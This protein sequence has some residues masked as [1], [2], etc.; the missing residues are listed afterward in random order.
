MLAPALAASGYRVLCPDVV[1]RGNSDRLADPRGYE[2]RQYVSDM[3]ALVTQ[4]GAAPVDWIGTSMGGLI[5]MSL[6]ARAAT[7]VRRLVI[8]D[9]GPFIPRAALQRLGTYVGADP[10]FPDLAAAEAS[11]RGTRAPFGKLTDEQW[12]T[13]AERTTRPDDAGGY[14]LHHDPGIAVRFHETSDQ[15]ADLWQVWDGVEGPVLVLRGRNSDLLLAETAAEMVTRGPE[16]K[17]IEFAGCGHAPALLEAPQIDAVV[18][19]LGAT[20]SD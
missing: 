1:G 18:D 4:L 2:L 20:R 8:N 12:R 11:L 14:R 13:M 5:G 7:P 19:W 15:D 9:I 10:T 6:A 3:A 17:V 16:A